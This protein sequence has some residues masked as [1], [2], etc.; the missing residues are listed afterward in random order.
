MSNTRIRLTLR[1]DQAGAKGLR[2]QYGERLVGVR[3]RYDAQQQK[4]DKTVE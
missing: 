2:A 1:P 3:Y 4:R